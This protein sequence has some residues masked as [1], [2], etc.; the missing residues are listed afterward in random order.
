MFMPTKTLDEA[1]PCRSHSMN[2]VSTRP[3]I[4]RCWAFLRIIWLCLFN[5]QLCLLIDIRVTIY[6]IR[7]RPIVPKRHKEASLLDSR[8]DC[9]H[10]RAS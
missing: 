10:N 5:G 7:L 2:G 9:L 8:G 1:P 3:G 6:R 4:V